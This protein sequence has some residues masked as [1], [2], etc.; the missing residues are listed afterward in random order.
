MIDW[1]IVKSLKNSCKFINKKLTEISGAPPLVFKSNGKPL[2]NYRIYGNT[3]NGVSVGDLVTEGEHAWEYCI[4]IKIKSNNMLENTASPLLTHRGIAYKTNDDGSISIQGTCTNSVSYYII[5][6]TGAYNNDLSRYTETIFNAGISIYSSTQ[7]EMPLKVKY[8][9]GSYGELNNNTFTVLP[10]DVGLIYVQ[11]NINTTINETIY[12]IISKE[13]TEYEP[14]W[15]S[16]DISLYMSEVLQ[17]VGDTADYIDFKTQKR[18]NAN[19]TVEKTVLPLI[20]TTNGTNHISIN[21]SVQPSII[22][23]KKRI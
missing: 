22:K 15:D 4:P 1:T 18:Y 3:V 7:T 16:I 20:P 2:K 14:Y 23:L 8:T 10:K 21:T 6:G 9:D 12:P 13:Y 19:G 17:K 11:V 5:A